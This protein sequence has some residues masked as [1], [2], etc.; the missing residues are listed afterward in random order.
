MKKKIY[1]LITLGLL[2]LNLNAQVEPRREMRATWVASVSNI[3]WPKNVHRGLPEEQK[4]D[5]IRMLDLYQTI[6]LNAI[7]LQVR[8]ECD[9]L[10][11]SSYEPWSR[12]LTGSQG[13]DPGYDPL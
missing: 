4:A 3:D 7:F 11:D 2:V 6:H 8:P 1:I 12:Y 10:Y 13:I 5:L 9:A